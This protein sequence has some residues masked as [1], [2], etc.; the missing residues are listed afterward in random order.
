MRPLDENLRLISIYEESMIKTIR[1]LLHTQH[2]EIETLRSENK[3]LK[4]SLQYRTTTINDLRFAKRELEKHIK[5]N[6]LNP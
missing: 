3:K 6:D 4:Q 1:T 2:E 5:M